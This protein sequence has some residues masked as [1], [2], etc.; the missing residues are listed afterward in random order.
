MFKSELHL[1]CTCVV[2][3]PLN[4]STALGSA[5]L[6]ELAP[7]EAPVRKQA[8]S[9]GHTAGASSVLRLHGFLPTL[10]WSPGLLEVTPAVPTPPHEGQ[11]DL[12]WGV[13]G[14]WFLFSGT[15]TA[16]FLLGSSFL[17][18]KQTPDSWGLHP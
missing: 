4:D 2:P 9:P 1:H 10:S 12:G 5:R 11:V 8:P 17:E 6:Q 3:V 13:V 15:I 14:G 18:C 16:F 7:T